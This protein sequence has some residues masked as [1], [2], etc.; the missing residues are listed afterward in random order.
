MLRDKEEEEEED[1]KKTGGGSNSRRLKTE[2]V[3]MWHELT[4]VLQN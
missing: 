4:V 3:T 1:A 2:P